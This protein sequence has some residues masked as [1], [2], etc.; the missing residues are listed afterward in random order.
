VHKLSELPLTSFPLKLLV[1]LFFPL[2][3][4]FGKADAVK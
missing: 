2:L 4:P 3:L 1:Q